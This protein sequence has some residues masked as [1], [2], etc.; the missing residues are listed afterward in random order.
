MPSPLLTALATFGSGN[1]GYNQ[2]QLDQYS[3]KAAQLRQKQAEQQQAALGSYI[4]ALQA[5]TNPQG[6]QQPPQQM[7]P[8]QP[9]VPT[10]QAMPTPVPQV[11]GPMQIPPV[12]AQAL[13]P[14]M[15]A[16][17]GGGTAPPPPMAPNIPLT[18]PVPQYSAPQ[19]PG[20]SGG[21]PGA[22]PAQP[23]ASSGDGQGQNY[24]DLLR[25]VVSAVNEAMPNGDPQTKSIVAQELMQNVVSQQQQYDQK[26]A[27]MALKESQLGE[28]ERNDQTIAGIRQQLADVATQKASTSASQGQQ[29]ID[30]AKDKAIK[31][32][33]DGGDEKLSDKA[34]QMIIQQLQA[35]DT[36]ALTGIGRGKNATQNWVRV[37]NGLADAGMSGSQLAQIEAE[38]QGLKAGERAV[39]TT[40]ARVAMFA[41]EAGRMARQALSASDNLPRGDFVPLTRAAQLVEAGTSS[42]ELKR[43][44]VANNALKN[45]W[46][47]TINGG[48][49]PTV[50]DKEE[51]SRLIET[52]DSPEAYEAG[53][54]Q[55]IQEMQAAQEAPRDVKQQLR[56][57]SQSGDQ[58]TSA[59]SAPPR[60]K[61]TSDPLGIR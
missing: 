30:I 47:K 14:N 22:A 38:F 52:A 57:N 51:F 3:V 27:A 18:R 41:S 21:H 19:M 45:T 23:D 5:L 56:D 7:A 50:S 24:Q 20:A 32:N 8:G 17:T 10:T 59:P 2:G 36:S 58:S 11:S 29:R 33:Q 55:I 28:R 13:Q 6:N 35:G 4:T 46:A 40:G 53:V 15:Q 12:N 16:P 49:V 1:Q 61:E 34:V 42:Q 44:V 25:R 26:K 37:K 31:A 60:A 54:D 43:F 48:S 39:G 9:S